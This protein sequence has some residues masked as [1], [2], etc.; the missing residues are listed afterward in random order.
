M[1]SNLPRVCDWVQLPC[2]RNLHEVTILVGLTQVLTGNHTSHNILLEGESLLHAVSTASGR[3]AI[4][5]CRIYNGH[6]YGTT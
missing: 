6:V 4:L 2:E 3:L 1:A 5:T